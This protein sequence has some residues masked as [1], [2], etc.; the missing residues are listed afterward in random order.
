MTTLMERLRKNRTRVITLVILVLLFFM[1]IQGMSTRD[2]L[3]TTL[4]GLSVG[5]VTFL[6]ASGLSLIFGLMDVL[7]LAHGALFMIGAYVGWSVY[8]RPDT[9]VD[10]LAPL[11]F[12]AAGLALRPLW[13]R[14]LARVRMPAGLAR[15]WPWIGLALAAIVLVFFLARIPVA[16]WDAEAYDDSPV[17]WTQRFGTEALQSLVTPARFETLSPIIGWGGLLLGSVLAGLSLS[18]VTRRR[19]GM[20]RTPPGR[21]RRAV[22]VFALLILLGLGVLL[23]NTPLTDFLFSLSST[24]L[25]LIAVVAAVLAGALLGG[26]MEATLI[27]PLY[28]RPI[29]QLMLTLGLGFIGTEVVRAVWGRTGFTMPKPALFAGGGDGC[30][31][32][33]LGGWLQNQCSTLTLTIGG[34][35]ARIRV[36]NELFTILV[37]LAVLIVVWLLLQR[38]RLGMIIRAGVQDSDMVETLGINVRQVFTLVFAL[39]AGL[40]ALGGVISAPATGL[41]D[42]MGGNLLLGAL[43]ALAIGGL[44][45]FP[46]AAAGS[47]LVGLFQQFIIKYGQIGIQLPFLEE[48]FKPSPTLVPAATVLLMVII[49]LAMPQ[50][51]LGRAE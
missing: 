34:E 32:E 22:A 18:G 39:G 47:V 46:G 17:V 38:S 23:I 48:P 44:T 36:Y 31:A 43:I 45:S 3:I 41:S 2:W 24:W 9:A 21:E 29:Y 26:L 42:A 11:A 5:A 30:P 16:I 20:A 19:R 40:A 28:A 27:R 1:A 4:R 37:G 51:L 15:V 13:E 8:A 35:T 12:L 14:L 6:A 33:S 25:F 50:G 7:N 10:L 49:L